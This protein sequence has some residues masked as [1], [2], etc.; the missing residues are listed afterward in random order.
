MDIKAQVDRDGCP[1]LAQ[2]TDGSPAVSIG[3][4]ADFFDGA[5]YHWEMVWHA[6][7]VIFNTDSGGGGSHDRPSSSCLNDVRRIVRDVN[8]KSVKKYNKSALSEWSRLPLHDKLLSIELSKELYCEKK[9]LGWGWG[10]R[11]SG[12]SAKK[13]PPLAKSQ[14]E[15]R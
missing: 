9:P 5:S 13:G 10:K 2:P 6:D 4:A 15:E 1:E 11:G 12:K 3:S 8:V 14:A 7:K